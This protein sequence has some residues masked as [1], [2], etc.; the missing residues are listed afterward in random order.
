[1]GTMDIDANYV[2]AGHANGKSLVGISRYAQEASLLT[3]REKGELSPTLTP[4]TSV[5]T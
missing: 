2:L 4:N 5:L 1:M 3:Q